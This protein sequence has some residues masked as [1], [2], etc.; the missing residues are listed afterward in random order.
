MVNET[1]RLKLKFDQ[2]KTAFSGQKP[3]ISSVLNL[4]GLFLRTILIHKNLKLIFMVI[5]K[6]QQFLLRYFDCQ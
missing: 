4:I 2:F 5:I 1:A 6:P 3:F